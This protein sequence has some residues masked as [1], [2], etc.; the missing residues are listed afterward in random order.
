[1]KLTSFGLYRLH[2]K[3]VVPARA[4]SGSAG[5]DLVTVEEERIPAGEVGFLRTGWALAERLPAYAELALMVELQIR[6]RSS[7]FKK[8]GL[9]IPNSPGTI[10]SDYTGE[11]LIQVYNM[12]QKEVVLP[13]GTRVAQLVV[14]LVATPEWR[15]W[16]VQIQEE[17][18]G[19]FGSTGA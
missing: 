11:I 2:D 4:T 9:I 15:E 6:P 14:A 16:F 8:Y 13:A 12:G 1:M 17:T 7:T 10:D 3:A 5:Y 19:G 18:R